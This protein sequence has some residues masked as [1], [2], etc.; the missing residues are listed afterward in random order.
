MLYVPGF[1]E[2]LVVKLNILLLNFGEILGD[3]FHILAC[4]TDNVHET[5]EGCIIKGFDKTTSNEEPSD[6]RFWAPFAG[7]DENNNVVDL[8]TMLIVF[9]I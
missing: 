6:E 8:L 5:A 7:F 4:I 1:A 9:L 3:T 2:L